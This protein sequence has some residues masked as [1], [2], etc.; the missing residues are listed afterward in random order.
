MNINRHEWV[1]QAT[2]LSRSATGR[3]EWKGRYYW[4]GTPEKVRVPSQFRTASRRS[5]QAG[6]LCYP[7]D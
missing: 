4:K 6:G 5:A 7:T 2:R 3:T 1:A